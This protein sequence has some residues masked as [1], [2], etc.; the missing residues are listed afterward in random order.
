MADVVIRAVKTRS[1]R[2]AFLDLPEKL[3]RSNPYWVPRLRII[4]AELAGFKHHPF[5][6]TAEVQ[7]F[8]ASRDGKDCGR[9]AAIINRE[10]NRE[11]KEERGFFG[12]F[13]SVDDRQ[14]A[15]A[16]LDAVRDW[17]K[18]RGIT[19]MRGPANPSM[20]Y[21]C[22]LLVEG[23]EIAPTFL[24]PYNP[25]YYE[26]LITSYGF[27]PVQ[28]LLAYVGHKDQLPNFE[29]ELGWLVDQA[30][31]RCQA[32]LR[33]MTPKAKDV[34]LFL[35]LYNRSFENMW[36][37]VPLTKDE[38]AE[39]VKTLRY[40]VSPD[41]ALIAEV[42]GKGVGAVL[43]LPDFNP[44][45]KKIRGRLFPFGFL[46]LLGA[47]KD[48]RRVRVISI[49]VVPEFQRWGLGLVLLRGLVPKALSMGVEEAEFSWIAE[50][51]MMPR[52]GLEKMDAKLEKKYRMYDFEPASNAS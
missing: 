16:L 42:D 25:A 43:G 7:T 36:G 18:Q 12:F 37:F 47:K 14:V 51:N 38:V 33:P 23:V 39:F 10:H 26:P 32:T 13:E 20:N 41:L 50:S 27:K 5:H 46:Q 48:L 17:L 1:D 45:I 4:E 2:R 49:N 30:Q 52:M 15:H 40:L 29:K 34:E 31:E 35:T 44:R 22:G 8:L 9:I 28:D 19:K 6:K 3:H 24:M 11:H 21:D